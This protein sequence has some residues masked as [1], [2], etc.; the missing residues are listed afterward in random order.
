MSDTHKLDN[1]LRDFRRNHLLIRLGRTVMTALFTAAIFW[2]LY[3][4]LHQHAP[5]LLY[6]ALIMLAFF[7]CFG[8]VSAKLTRALHAGSVLLATGQLDDAEHWLRQAATGFSLSARLQL[9]AGQSLATVYFQRD[10]HDWVIALCRELL[11]H[12]LLRSLSHVWVATRLMLADSLLALDRVGEAYEALRP[13]YDATLSLTDRLKLLPLQLRYELAAE[14]PESAVDAMGEKIQLAEILDARRAA[15]VHALL[16]EAC[17]RREMAR[18]QAY[19]TERARL[20]HD[21]EPLA[22][23]YAVLQPIAGINQTNAE[24]KEES[25]AASQENPHT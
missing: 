3:P 15:L 23:D 2:M 8:Y 14:H 1:L 4:P 18:E 22:E 13:V 20:Y 10:R 19:L 12:R 9:A 24:L 17:R 5:S 21:L 6:I 7:L 25:H 16:A 11:D